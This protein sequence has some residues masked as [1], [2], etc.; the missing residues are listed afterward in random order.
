MGV[1]QVLHPEGRTLGQV[2]AL[3]EEGP[4]ARTEAAAPSRTRGNP[5]TIRAG[6]LKVLFKFVNNME[7]LKINTLL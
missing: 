4:G 6:I 2:Q 3:A 5:V 1:R 7:Y